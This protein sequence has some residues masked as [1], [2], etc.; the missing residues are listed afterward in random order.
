M[1]LASGA[2]DRQNVV[3]RHTIRFN[4]ITKLPETLG[5]DPMTLAVGNGV[6]A[7]NADITGMYTLNETYTH[8]FT[9]TTLSD[10]GW[11]S[12]P[13]PENVDPFRSYQY[14]YFNTTRSEPASDDSKG[15]NSF[16]TK[17][18]PYP[19]VE[20]EDADDGGSWLR[21]NPHRLDLI[22]VALPLPLAMHLAGL[23]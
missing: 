6:L 22:Q 17:K 8:G 23:I 1:L 15:T 10:W 11:H 2:I 5:K 20:P 7:F 3:R 12:E 16:G 18:V 19:V 13:P 9:L 14:T 4:G 21:E